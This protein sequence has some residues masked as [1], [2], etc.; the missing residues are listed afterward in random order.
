MVN[1]GLMTLKIPVS[2]ENVN[3]PMRTDL[4][5]SVTMPRIPESAFSPSNVMLFRTSEAVMYFGLSVPRDTPAGIYYLEWSK[6]GDSQTTFA[7]DVPSV[8]NMYSNIRVS[9]VIV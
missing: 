3:R 2:V 7:K 6:S 1:P 5:L 9:T 4:T 8:Y